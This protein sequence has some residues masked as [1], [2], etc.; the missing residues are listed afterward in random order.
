MLFHNTIINT[1]TLLIPCSDY[2][3]PLTESG[4]YTEK[5]FSTL[6]KIAE[7]DPLSSIIKHPDQP[8]IIA[9]MK[10]K[11]VEITEQMGFQDIL[12]NVVSLQG[13]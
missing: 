4:N 1:K 10:Y 11:D 2:D 9:P 8:E 5:Y 12:N 3:A 13:E 7:Y 6:L